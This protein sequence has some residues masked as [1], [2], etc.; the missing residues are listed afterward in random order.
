MRKPNTVTIDGEDYE[1]PPLT[2]EM[3]NDPDFS[4]E[5]HIESVLR[6]I[7]AEAARRDERDVLYGV[8]V[9]GPL[10]IIDARDRTRRRD[11]PR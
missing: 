5:T 4:M 1:I 10:G 7:C 9:G 8:G 6:A 11:G 2:I 3:L